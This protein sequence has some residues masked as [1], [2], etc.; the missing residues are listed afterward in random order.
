V[1]S[2]IAERLGLTDVATLDGRHLWWSGRPAA[3]CGTLLPI[4]RPSRPTPP[5]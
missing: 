1:R 3:V 4:P 2:A 5:P